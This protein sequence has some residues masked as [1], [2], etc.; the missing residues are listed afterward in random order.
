M[1]DMSEI[2]SLIE[3]Q[4]DAFADFRERI[5]NELKTERK[6][7]EELEARINRQGFSGGGGKSFDPAERK[8]IATFVRKGDD[9]E[10]KAMSVGSDPDGGYVVLPQMAGS[11]LNKLREVSPLGNLARRVTMGPGDS[12]EEPQ[13]DGD[14]GAEWTGETSARNPTTSPTLKML[15]IPLAEC[16]ATV[17]VTQRLLDD[18][19]FD[20]GAWIDERLANRFARLEGSSFVSGNGILKPRGITTYDVSTDDDSTRAADTLEY[21]A[22]GASGAFAGTEPE[23]K[24]VDLVYSLRA[25]YRAN[26]AWMMNRATAG[27][28]RK[29][30]DGNDRFLWTDSLAAGEPAQLLGFPVYLDEEMPAIAADSLSIAFGDFT[31]GYTVIE[32]PGIKMLRDP[33]TAKPNVDFY[34]TR[35]VG[36]GVADFD[37]IKLMKFSAS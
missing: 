10:L 31:R 30:K 21:V 27:L 14:A 26:A 24:L 18:A 17:R 20:L 19:T 9:S 16:T 11:I 23:D 25:P 33:F 1:T 32:R 5:D 6:E 2:K 13:E 4:G 7:R 8:A 34:A 29:M 28:I 22:S 15:K 35:R 12:W 37:A 3:Q 36:G